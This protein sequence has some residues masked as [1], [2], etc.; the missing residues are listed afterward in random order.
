MAIVVRPDIGERTVR[1]ILT[2]LPLR[3]VYAL[4]C[5]RRH[6]L[7]PIN[8]SCAPT[9]RGD[10]RAIVIFCDMWRACH[11]AACFSVQP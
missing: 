4:P 10:I 7:R 3:T 8:A 6:Q 9:Y 1:V 11:N 5:L 2:F